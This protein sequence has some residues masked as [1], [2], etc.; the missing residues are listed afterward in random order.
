MNYLLAA[1]AGVFLYAGIMHALGSRELVQRLFSVLCCVAAAYVISN[2]LAN[3][4]PSPESLVTAIRWR[5]A[6]A[7]LFQVVFI[8]FVRAQA[9]AIPSFL[10]A[11]FVA[12]YAVPFVANGLAPDGI[13]FPILPVLGPVPERTY[14][15]PAPLWLEF[16]WLLHLAVYLTALNACRIDYRRGRRREAIELAI[17][18]TALPLIVLLLILDSHGLESRAF[19][20][21]W[22]LAEFAFLI[23][24]LMTSFSLRR[25]LEAVK[26]QLRALVDNVPAYV[27]MKDR[28]GRY[29]F[30]NRYWLDQFQRRSEDSLGKTDL[31][32]F[33]PEVA[34][35]YRSNDQRVFAEGKLLEFE[36]ASSPRSDEAR[37]YSSLK[38]P[39][40]GFDGATRVLGGI[41]T[42]VTDIVRLQRALKTSEL[43]LRSTMEAARISSWELHY[44]SRS[45]R[46]SG[47]AHLV[48]GLPAAGLPSTLDAALDIIYPEDRALVTQRID[49]A[50]NDAGSDY[51]AEYRV[52][53]PD[54]DI[55]WVEARGRAER[56]QDGD[57]GYMLGTV[58]DITQRK[59]AEESLRVAR[60][61]ELRTRE[62]F[63]QHL[64]TAQEQERK[65]LANDLHDGLGQSL[66]LIKNRAAMALEGEKSA[67]A[68][69]H[70][71]SIVDLAVTSIGELR[72]LVQSLRPVHIE[73]LGLTQSLRGLLDQTAQS[74]SI[75]LEYELEDVDDLFPGESS[76]HLYRIVQEGL[77]NMLK[78][79]QATS[80]R[81]SVERDIRCVRLSMSDDGQGFDAQGIP[82][83]GLGL[84]SIVERTHM[85]DGV[86]SL[87]SEPGHG[88][89]IVI[90]FPL[91]EIAD[92]VTDNLQ[93]QPS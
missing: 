47:N 84:T 32:I 34:S 73:Q 71:N 49:Q 77:S 29:V 40:P 62:E 59:H 18:F 80:G 50:R 55:R 7:I 27:F 25:Q 70:L 36:E 35:V 31:E 28:A 56:G 91:R 5:T 10:C 66:S 45:L 30:V 17:A 1:M 24:L 19:V 3:L 76:T 16:I 82:L 43:R 9:P 88:T 51:F 15:D 53:R 12:A 75:R 83:N 61:A 39:I 68:L 11:A 42:D 46:W 58:M 21:E 54:G 41:S 64:L 89:Q 20:Y 23:L 74:T 78:H 4:A 85:L 2:L 14:A 22:H 69:A 87:T 63:A 26:T 48:H 6:F 86:F 8:L 57:S 93:A 38:F 52:I 90:E 44:A 13:S 60:E 72:G 33:Q 79:S 92:A 67:V 37:I 81:I 65:R